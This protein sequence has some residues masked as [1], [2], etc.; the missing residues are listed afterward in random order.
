MRCSSGNFRPELTSAVVLPEPG[1]PMN[2]YH[3]RSY[4]PRPFAWFCFSAA[5][6]SSNRSRSCTASSPGRP[7][8]AAADLATPVMSLSVARFACIRR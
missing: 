6:A 2:A 7:A 5:I 4:K 3:G 1:A 8:S